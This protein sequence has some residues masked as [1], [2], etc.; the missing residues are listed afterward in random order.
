MRD[1]LWTCRDGR[2]LLVSQM[3]TSHVINSV[4]KIR[5][6]AAEGR[7]WRTRYLERLELELLIRQ[8]RGGDR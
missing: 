8:I 2:T 3:E 4:N 5:R 7:P 6:H 1:T